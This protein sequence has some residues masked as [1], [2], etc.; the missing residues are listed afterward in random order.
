MDSSTRSSPYTVYTGVA[1]EDIEDKSTVLKVLSYDLNPQAFQGTL[2][3]GITTN[4]VSITDRDGKPIK[5]T[6]TTTNHITATWEGASNLRYPPMVRKGEPVEIYKIGNQDKWWWRT[7]GRGRDFRTTDR[8]VFEVSATD[9]TKPG[10]EK[11]DTNTYS[12]YLDSHNK[13]IGFS[14]STANGEAV[15]MV[16]EADLTNGTFYLTDNSE[17]PGN[18]IF[19]D[20]GAK[21]GSPKFQ[22]NIRSGATFLFDNEHC[23]I[24]VPKTTLIQSGERIVFD[25]PLTI[26]NTSKVGAIIFNCSS[27]VIDTTK[28]IILKASGVIGLNST[29]TKIMG[30][31]T[32]A[33]V[34]L[35]GLFKG[36]VGSSYTPTTVSDVLDG[37]VSEAN[38]S[39]DTDTSTPVTNLPV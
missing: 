30:V 23:I 14:S 2:A 15:G 36:P 9:P 13:K 7:T 16:M 20:T 19:L 37:S 26:F 27:F 12:A 39:P 8:V 38:N 10:G 28:D 18:R 32:A 31:L 21:S 35:S 3:P 24:K 22:V 33:S 5:S 17:S 4:N 1:V 34:R 6:N 29:A 25:S 11:N